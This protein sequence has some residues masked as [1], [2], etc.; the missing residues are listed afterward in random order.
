M[1]QLLVYFD[2]EFSSLEANGGLLS[3]GCVTA[4][5]REFYA[6]L[7]DTWTPATCTDFVRLHVLPKLTGQ[8][9]ITLTELAAR[10]RAWLDGLGGP[11]ELASDHP[12]L[13]LPWIEA[14]FKDGWPRNLSRECRTIKIDSQAQRDYW[15]RHPG[16]Q[17]HALHDAR[18][19]RAGVQ[20]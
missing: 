2:T 12:F 16:M 5:G 20:R 7:V 17:H 11:V 1:T 14:L 3:I 6:E 19:L 13:D 15:L 9:R 10:L 18:A 8:E 4:D